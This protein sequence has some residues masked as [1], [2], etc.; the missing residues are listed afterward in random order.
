MQNLIYSEMIL[1][2]EKNASEANF[3][4]GLSS[5]GRSI[6]WWLVLVGWWAGRTGWKQ[7]REVGI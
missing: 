3:L 2:K 4:W 5:K 6:K 7:K 1:I